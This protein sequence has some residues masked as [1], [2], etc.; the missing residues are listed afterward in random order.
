MAISERFKFNEC[1]QRE[2]EK[3]AD[4]VAD[5]KKLA[6]SC[7]FKDFLNEDLRDRCLCG[8]KP[9]TIQRKLLSEGDLTF[10][11]A[12]ELATTM[13]IAD[14]DT[15][16]FQPVQGTVKLMSISYTD[17]S[18]SLKRVEIVKCIKV[19]LYTQTQRDSV[20]AVEIPIARKHASL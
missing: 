6:I 14:Q 1:E 12:C 13:E 16:C 5:L 8:L 15:A 9:E 4:Y 19:E 2:R 18:Q 17:G 7:E 20:T 10:Q 3:I 11:K